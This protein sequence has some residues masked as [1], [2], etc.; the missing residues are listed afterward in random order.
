[1]DENHIAPEFYVVNRKLTGDQQE[2]VRHALSMTPIS[3]AIVTNIYDVKLAHD[4][5][6]EKVYSARY[7]AE[8]RAHAQEIFKKTGE[9]AL[10]VDHA[11]FLEGHYGD[12]KIE[13][14][15]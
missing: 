5:G 1:M 10:V 9:I 7:P 15:L 6:A 12:G 13:T 8:A 3:C 11:V 4:L 14:I 2:A